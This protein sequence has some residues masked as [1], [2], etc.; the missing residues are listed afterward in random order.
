MMN[1]LRRCVL[2]ALLWPASLAPAAAQSAVA[3]PVHN[4]RVA[5]TPDGALA[6][7]RKAVQE[8]WS[9][10]YDSRVLGPYRQ[11]AEVPAGAANGAT[12]RLE[13]RR[14][15]GDRTAGLLKRAFD[16]ALVPDGGATRVTVLVHGPYSEVGRD[17]E[18]WLSGRVQCF[19]RY[20]PMP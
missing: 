10:D 17:V 7:L 9:D 14:V 11:V 4:F 2:A 1:V 6:R 8:C 3:V 12:I 5:G 13:W 16:I 19:E 18:A 20:R 15:V